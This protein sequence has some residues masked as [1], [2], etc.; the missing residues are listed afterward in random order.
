M[1]FSFIFLW[2][3]FADFV[4]ITSQLTMEHF[5]IKVKF[6]GRLPIFL[7]IEDIFGT[8]SGRKSMHFKN[9]I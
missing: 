6:S 5:I 9:D 2:K 8:T 7:F 4:L 3:S 1:P